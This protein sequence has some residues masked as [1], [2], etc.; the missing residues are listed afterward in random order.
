MDEVSGL[1]TVVVVVVTS[2]VKAER[3]EYSSPVWLYQLAIACKIMDME[4][5]IWLNGS[6]SISRVSVTLRGRHK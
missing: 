5:D 1:A 3:C 6:D 4:S 2:R